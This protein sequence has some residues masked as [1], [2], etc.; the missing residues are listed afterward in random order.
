MRTIAT[1][2]VSSLFLVALLVVALPTS[3]GGATTYVVVTGNSMEPTLHTGDLAILRTSADYG[4]GE[5]VAFRTSA[6][7][8]I[9]R[10]V[11]TLED[12]TYVLRGDNRVTTD[13]WHPSNREVLGTHQMTIPHLGKLLVWLRQPSVFGVLVALLALGWLLHAGDGRGLRALRRRQRVRRVA[14]ATSGEAR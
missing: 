8:V 12:A 10:I 14:A 2:V 7:N 5:V 6:G 3:L 9:H 11:D 4:V 13:Q 1:R